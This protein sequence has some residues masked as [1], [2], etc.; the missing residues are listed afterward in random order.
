[1]KTLSTTKRLILV[2]VSVLLL[3]IGWL[4]LSGI[5]LLF[6][7]VP[8]MIIS[9][10]YTA[11]ARDFFRMLGWATMAFLLWS[12]ASIWWVSIAHWSGPVTAGIVGTFWSLVAFMTYHYVSK[13]APRA[14]A[15]TIFV[16]LWVTTEYLYYSAEVMTF[17]WLLL[18]HGFSNDIWAVQ[19]YEYTGVFGGSLWVM[20]SNVSIFEA[21]RSR[22]KVAKVRATIISLLPIIASVVIYFT[23][24]PSDSSV[25]LSAVQPNVACYEGKD[26]TIEDVATFVEEVPEDAAAVVMPESALCYIE[27]LDYTY[28]EESLNHYAP[29]FAKLFNGRD[30]NLKMI[31]GA[32]T[33]EHYGRDKATSTARYSEAYDDYYDVYNTALCLNSCGEVEDIYHKAKLVIGVEAMPEFVTSFVDLGGVSGQLGWGREHSVFNIG[34]IKVGPAICYEALYSDYF[35]GFVRKGANVMAVISN[36]GWWGNTPGHKRLFDFCRLRAIETRRSIARSAN[37]GI[38]GFI[39]PRGDIQGDVLEW[40]EQGVL[41]QSVE[42]RDDSTLYVLYG[43][44]VARISIYAAVLGLLYYVAYRVRR[45]NHLVE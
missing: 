31:L 30:D 12:V 43:D 41:T 8:L 26:I 33:S 32:S 28:N 18:G 14:L 15:Y 2:L 29:I 45:R 11:S 25:K 5:T 35:A 22:C 16:A 19:W 44:W 10:H 36:D 7:L 23:Y 1:M 9:E 17:P 20:A 4:G 40:E 37:T 39:T 21:M 34:D 13:R 27:Y 38:S 24:T 42:V 3:S 6:A